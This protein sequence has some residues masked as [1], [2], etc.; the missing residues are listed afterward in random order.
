MPS[1]ALY[2]LTVPFSRSFVRGC[3]CLA[4]LMTIG[5][6][7]GQVIAQQA[8]EPLFLVARPQLGDPRFA[9]SVVLVLRHGRS[10][11]MGVVLNKPLPHRWG[12]EA[13]GE[14]QILFYGGPVSSE[15]FVYLFE[16]E[17][18]V[19]D[20]PDLLSMGGSLY[21]GMG[22]G[23]PDEIRARQPARRFRL[24]RGLSSWGHGQLE[25]E[26]RRGDWLVL[27][28]DPELAMRADT[29]RLWETLIARASQRS[30]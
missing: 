25:N 7:N 16:A 18:E 4:G 12:K 27:P 22:R 10:R 3:L 13:A 23:M 21:M 29:G 2:F 9:E 8:A 17:R 26:I 11:P 1:I 15:I 24:F 14:E 19:G 6:W 20:R 30:I 5:L 28:Y